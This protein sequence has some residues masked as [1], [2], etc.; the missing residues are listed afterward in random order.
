MYLDPTDPVVEDD[1]LTVEGNALK[2]TTTEDDA[3][4]QSIS[5]LEFSKK[6]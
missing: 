3:D 5:V 2:L 6:I 1:K 4:P